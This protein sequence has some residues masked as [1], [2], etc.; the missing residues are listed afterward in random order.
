M[1]KTITPQLIE[2][3]GYTKSELRWMV[4]RYRGSRLPARTLD[5]WIRQLFVFDIVVK[6]D[7]LGLYDDD[8]LKLLTRLVFWLQRR[9]T[10]A[11]FAQIIK[12]ESQNA[13]SN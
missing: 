9:Q 3:A 8:C 5:H 1:S 6:P 2:Q 11:Q 4:A 13:S 7:S 10:I 12:Q